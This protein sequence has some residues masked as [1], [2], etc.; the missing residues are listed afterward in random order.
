MEGTLKRTI[1]KNNFIINWGKMFPRLWHVQISFFEWIKLFSLKALFWDWGDFDFSGI[2]FENF[3][4]NVI[5]SGIGKGEQNWKNPSF[6]HKMQNTRTFQSGW[7]RM[8]IKRSLSPFSDCRTDV[9]ESAGSF[10]HLP[11][12]P[13]FVSD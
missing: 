5:C 9:P 2:K 1:D 8:V 11:K 13:D 12:V 6:L 4:N 7:H 3:K 10:K